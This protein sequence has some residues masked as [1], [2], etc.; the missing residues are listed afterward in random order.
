M[1]NLEEIKAQKKMGLRTGLIQMS[2]YDLNSVELL[3]PKIREAIDGDLVQ[4][5]VYGEKVSCDVLIVRHPPI[6]EDWQQYIPDVDAKNI[7]VIVNQP[8]KRDYS[9]E[10]ETLYHLDRCG[11]HLETYF[12]KRGQWYP[13]GPLIRETLHKHHADELKSIQLE[14][15]DWVNIIDVDEWKRST[16][17]TASSKVKIGRHSRDQYVKWPVEKEQLLSI[18]PDSDPYEIHVLGGAKSP[19][20]VLGDLPANWNIVEFG[21]VEPKD[22]LAQLDV[23]VYYTHPDWIEAFGRVIF[24]A[25]AVGVPVIISPQYKDLFKEAAIYAEP[26]EVKGKI[27]ELMSD[28]AYYKRQVDMAYAYV[29]NQFGYSKHACRLEK[30]VDER[31]QT[32]LRT[33]EGQTV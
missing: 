27:D 3:N 18:Y 28:A 9:E 16:R 14:Q 23:F 30:Y 7:Q 8:P 15:E 5:L 10:G 20:K 25:M 13:I 12:G 17:S 31:K 32:G 4:L 6:L 1:S 21:K 2:R 11:N 22:F 29:E 24:E 26:E 33:T 19:K